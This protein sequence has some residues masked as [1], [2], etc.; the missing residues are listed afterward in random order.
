MTAA[1]KS[2]AGLDVRD[3]TV[4]YP[5]AARP[6]IDHVSFRVEPGRTLSLVGPSGAGKST[7]LR[8]VCGLVKTDSGQIRCGER[9]LDALPPQ[10]RRT[11]MVFASDALVRTM[12][13][14]KN[15]EMVAR[16]ARA[17]ALALA[18][19]LDV[20]QHLEKRPGT[21]STGERQRVSIA[22]AV[23]SNPDVLLLDEP[24]APLDPDLRLRVRE[25]ILSVRG[26]FVG[27]IVFVTHDH[28]DAMAVGDDLAVLIDGRIED[29]GDPQ[30]VYDRPATLRAARF[31]GARPMNVVD[32]SVF[33]SPEHV[34]AF[35]PERAFIGG[36][37]LDGTVTRVERAGADAY[38]HVIAGAE[39]IA[40]RVPAETI[41]SLGARISIGVRDRD[42]C[43]YDRSTGCLV[44]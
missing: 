1:A 25:E 17:R 37:A 11:A 43:Y 35:R 8:A 41:P 31:L 19:A 36:D 29:A 24:L 5:H 14:R 6:A 3:L 34:V 4:T 18:Q 20:A 27:P 26:S 15:L 12:S 21:L 22:R 10:A 28:A 39:T 42:R 33:A 7:V 38:V 2:A 9:S 16:D 23:L 40:V 32:G 44:E 13:V 30:R